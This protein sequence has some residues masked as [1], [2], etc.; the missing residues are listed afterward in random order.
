M[1][2]GSASPSRRR[3]P[4]ASRLADG[5]SDWLPFSQV[6][7][8]WM[9]MLSCACCTQY[10]VLP[11]RQVSC[12]SPLVNGVLLHVL[13]LPAT[14]RLSLA[15]CLVVLAL[16]RIE[17]IPAAL[18]TRLFSGCSKIWGSYWPVFDLLSCT[19]AAV[20]PSQLASPF[21]LQLLALYYKLHA[22]LHTHVRQKRAKR[23]YYINQ[24][25]IASPTRYFHD[26]QST[27]RIKFFGTSFLRT[28]TY[29]RLSQAYRDGFQ[30]VWQ[31]S[32]VGHRVRHQAQFY[33]TAQRQLRQKLSALFCPLQTAMPAA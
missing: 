8:T 29:T 14:R 12:V 3:G 13:S 31:G 25:P 20:S 22:R 21:S 30:Q 27:L 4:W 6:P 17:P 1:R 7:P 18:L 26:L 9:R 32:A 28:L 24:P 5:A 15:Y 16:V 11:P 10:F 19:D 23:L 2:K 33:T